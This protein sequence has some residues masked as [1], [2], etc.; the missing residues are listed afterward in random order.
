MTA[1][2]LPPYMW[3][4]AIPHICLSMKPDM[5][6]SSVVHSPSL[7]TLCCYL[8]C[9]S[10]GRAAQMRYDLQQATQRGW[11]QSWGWTHSPVPA[12][13]SI[14]HATS[15]GM[16]HL[17]ASTSLKLWPSCCFCT[18]WQ[19]PGIQDVFVSTCKAET[20]GRAQN[21][22][23]RWGIVIGVRV[24][25]AAVLHQ[26]VGV[27]PGHAEDAI[28][29]MKEHVGQHSAMAVHDDNLSISSAKEYL[30]WTERPSVPPRVSHWTLLQT[31]LVI[32]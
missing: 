17:S 15:T 10:T 30:K 1:L 13:C 19:L 4:I 32:N 20:E 27:V 26:E 3:T 14:A 7:K 6:L 16:H 21:T 12:L 29:L 11:W 22:T 2:W 8:S 28:W 24:A 23:L 18:A 25:L 31:H 9:S 5:P